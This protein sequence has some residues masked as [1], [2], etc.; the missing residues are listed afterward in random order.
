MERWRHNRNRFILVEN[1]LNALSEITA[2]KSASYFSHDFEKNTRLYCLGNLKTNI[3]SA[4]PRP[5]YEVLFAVSMAVVLFLV[6]FDASD[7]L[8]LSSFFYGVLRLI[9]QAHSVIS[10]V[11]L[12]QSGLVVLRNTTSLYFQKQSQDD[13]ERKAF[14]NG[15]PLSSSGKPIIQVH[16]LAY[17][18][19]NGRGLMKP[20]SF[21]LRKG[22]IVWITGSN[23][24]GKSTL[25]DLLVG[26]L[27]IQKGLITVFSEKFSAGKVTWPSG[28]LGVV[29]Q[30]LFMLNATIEDNI[31]FGRKYDQTKMSKVSKA[32]D[33]N[34]TS[35][36]SPFFA[37]RVA[38]NSTNRLSGGQLQRVVLARAIYGEPRVLLLDEFSSALDQR[39]RGSLTKKIRRLVD[40]EGIAVLVVAHDNLDTDFY[41]KVIKLDVS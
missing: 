20:I 36:D 40:K 18:Y 2:Y 27:N 33:L 17:S 22:E 11:S 29:P 6:E 41:D 30:K 3:I 15:R 26:H 31:L 1:I 23:G 4:L 9:P 12:I 13:T 39:T 7:Y 38:D 21:S 32:L 25:L 24:A 5:V 8:I 19:K 34:L 16:K 35:P 37:G 10:N 14:F 28:S